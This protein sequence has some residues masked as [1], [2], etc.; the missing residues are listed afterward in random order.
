MSDRNTEIQPPRPGRQ[1]RL[2]AE[3][4]QLLEAAGITNP[5]Q[6][7]PRGV[8]DSI[9]QRLDRLTLVCGPEC[10]HTDREH[11]AFD[12]GYTGDFFNTGGDEH[13]H[14]IYRIGESAGN[15]T[16]RLQAERAPVTGN[17]WVYEQMAH[18][19]PDVQNVIA[20]LTNIKAEDEDARLH[21][22]GRIVRTNHDRHSITFA[23]RDRFGLETTFEISK[24]AV[25]RYPTGG[26]TSVL[27]LY[28]AFIATFGL[29]EC[30]LSDREL[31]KRMRESAEYCSP[32]IVE[33][34]EKP[35]EK[36]GGVR[37]N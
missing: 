8:R 24:A 2:R 26:T 32:M 7:Q 12:A 1:E 27:A 19:R 28:P 4:N 3:V 5:G 11:A 31:A 30:V 20:E 22:Y 23:A 9:L 25:R 35:A 14:A 16:R 34:E 13:L 36:L 17:E 21:I 15:E 29:E 6:F 18:D 33:R 37:I 10:D